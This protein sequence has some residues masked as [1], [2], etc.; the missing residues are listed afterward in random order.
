M[1]NNLYPMEEV[2]PIVSD[3]AY[4][5]TGCDHSSVTYERAQMLMEAVLYCI[6]EYEQN[7]ENTNALLA[8]KISAKEAYVHGRKMVMDKLERLQVLY[9]EIIMDFRAYGSACLHDTIRKGIPAFLEKYDYT[10][11]PQETLLTLD[12]PVLADL[13]DLSGVDRVF[14]YVQYIALEQKF[15]QKMDEGYIMES[16]RRYHRDYEHL[17]ENICE[18]VLQD[19]L[20]HGMPDRMF[21]EAY[22]F[23]ALE[24]LVSRYYDNNRD[25]LEY[26]KYGIPNIVARMQCNPGSL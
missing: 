17:V 11:A 4:K 10:Y 21:D 3:L 16:L 14:A 13:G 8:R 24:Q 5:Y 25:L 2:M 22:A 1:E 9:N 7:G 12:Y 19:M 15:M 6:N 18:I 26:I 20:G 23:K